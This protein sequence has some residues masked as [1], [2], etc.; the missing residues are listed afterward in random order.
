MPRLLLKVIGE[1][2]VVGVLQDDDMTFTRPPPGYF[3]AIMNNYKLS[4]RDP[5]LQF[6]KVTGSCGYWIYRILNP[7][8]GDLIQA[9]DGRICEPQVVNYIFN[10]DKTLIRDVKVNLDDPRVARKLQFI[11][12]SNPAFSAPPFYGHGSPDDAEEKVYELVQYWLN[13]QSMLHYIAEYNRSIYHQRI[14]RPRTFRGFVDFVGEE[15][16]REQHI[17]YSGSSHADGVAVTPKQEKEHVIN[18]AA[19]F[20]RKLRLAQE[21]RDT[22]T[23][24]EKRPV[25]VANGTSDRTMFLPKASAVKVELDEHFDI[26][27]GKATLLSLAGKHKIIDSLDKAKAILGDIV[28]TCQDMPALR[29][30]SLSNILRQLFDNCPILELMLCMQ[31]LAHLRADKTDGTRST[32][33]QLTTVIVEITLNY[34][35]EAFRAEVLQFFCDHNIHDILFK[36]CPIR[37]Q[38]KCIDLCNGIAKAIETAA[39]KDKHQ[40]VVESELLASEPVDKTVTATDLMTHRLAKSVRVTAAA[41]AAP[42]D[43]DLSS[44]DSQ[45]QLTVTT[46]FETAVRWIETPA[47][48]KVLRA[49]FTALLHSN[50]EIVTETHHGRPTLLM[51]ALANRKVPFEVIEQLINESVINQAEDALAHLD[52][53]RK[54]LM[55][56]WV[57][58]RDPNQDDSLK[59]LKMIFP[60]YISSIQRKFARFL[61]S[62]AQLNYVPV[63][64]YFRDDDGNTFVQE[65]IGKV[66]DPHRLRKYFEYI[67]P[68]MTEDVS[69]QAASPLL[70]AKNRQGLNALCI[71]K[72]REYAVPATDL[73]SAERKAA[74]A[75]AEVP[76]KLF[77]NRMGARL[78]DKQVLIDPAAFGPDFKNVFNFQ[79]KD[80]NDRLVREFKKGGAEAITRVYRLIQDQMELRGKMRQGNIWGRG[81]VDLLGDNNISPMFLPDTELYATLCIDMYQREKDPDKPVINSIF[82]AWLNS[83]EVYTTPVECLSRYLYAFTIKQACP[84]QD[85]IAT[86]LALIKLV[87]KHLSAMPVHKWKHA[88]EKRTW[89]HAGFCLYATLSFL[90]DLPD[91]RLDLRASFAELHFIVRCYTL[92]RDQREVENMLKQVF[93][94]LNA[95]DKISRFDGDLIM[96]LRSGLTAIVPPGVTKE[97]ALNDFLKVCKCHE[98][99]PIDRINDPEMRQ[100]VRDNFDPL[101]VHATEC[102]R[103]VM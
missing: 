100:Q 75:W 67:V 18:H 53:K 79:P 34:P 52:N 38:N 94:L 69:L 78:S 64:E 74:H 26:E 72:D 19:E 40:V 84:D 90:S 98:E 43:D 58:H 44:L 8:G 23:A 27:L 33:D 88:N 13:T 46:P 37:L 30:I 24:V 68:R 55:H 60:I 97:K 73:K 83:N 76:L 99:G 54:G 87:V 10:E 47:F 3:F 39:C 48:S 5:D 81:F 36:H 57:R 51:L 31:A 96:T 80:P 66:A 20:W 17:K 91:L 71:F 35:V 89:D 56:F 93:D 1:V 59:I 62:H 29:K 6:L 21:N 50:P 101:A 32:G 65:L 15:V 86:C 25:L 95:K 42:V 103:V 9:Q 16:R 12:F 14:V 22:A 2:N 4:A 49:N 102:M 28:Q 41:K 85:E 77:Y 82:N 7:Y 92:A 11:F 61:D 70:I 63:M 45:E